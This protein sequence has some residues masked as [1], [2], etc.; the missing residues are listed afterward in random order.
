MNILKYNF[1]HSMP[2]VPTRC[3]LYSTC[4]GV[5]LWQHLGNIYGFSIIPSVI[6]LRLN[7]IIRKGFYKLGCYVGILSESLNLEPVYNAIREILIASSRLF[8]APSNFV[9]GY[10][11][12]IS[13]SSEINKLR[14]ASTIILT[15]GSIFIFHRYRIHSITNIFR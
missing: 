14:L 15:G 7:T 2:L 1:I 8:S 6:I 10:N 3:I 12:N 9:N 13:Y 11:Q 5:I 4:S